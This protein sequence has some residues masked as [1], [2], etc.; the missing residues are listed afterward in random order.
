M[1]APDDMTLLREYSA[2]NSETAFETLV[3]RR[4]GFV[5][6]AALRQVRDPHLAED[7]TQAV[8]IILAQKAARI[9]PETILTGWLFK[10]TRFAALAQTRTAA[11]RREREQEAQMQTEIQHAAPDPLW[12]QLSPMLD[13]A[14]ASLG[15]TDR[16]A[17]LLRFFE[18]KALAEV[19][20]ALKT[21]EDTARKRVTRALEKLRKYFSRRGVVSTAALIAG[22]LS[23]QSVQAAPAHLAITITATAIKGSTVAASTLTLVKG[24][25]NVMAWIK[26]KIAVV[27]GASTLLAGVTIVTLHAQEEHI[28]A[29][30]EK[31]RAQEQFL[32][33]QAQQAGLT[34]E[35]RQAMEDQLQA[36]RDRQNA[37]R[38][39]QNQL[40][41]QDTNAFARPLL[42]ISP[43][44]A[45]RFEGDK[46]MVTYSGAEY[47]L[48][49][50]DNLTISSILTFC[51]SQYR[52][53]QKRI[54]EDLPVVLQDMKQPLKADHTVGLTLLD[55]NSGEKKLIANALMTEENRQAIMKTRL[56][57]KAGNSQN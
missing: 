21:N 43:F 24:T 36:L 20:D 54:A 17:I 44:T 19:G 56:A 57:D 22:A 5:Y 45:M 52:D 6:S 16:R 25:L 27:I 10:T 40:R 14:L 11:K 53:W 50:I 18:N 42:Q 23:S 1:E 8:F 47:E 37:L 46:V 3:S 34:P 33:T 38:S 29:Q 30:E 35:Q 48:A 51:K 4:V 39:Q 12:E 13:E 26:A 7:V 41:N 9:S 55:P 15:E 49:G 2:R 31:I 32:R 28:R